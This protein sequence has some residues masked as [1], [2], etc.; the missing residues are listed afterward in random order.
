M[1]LSISDELQ[2]FCRE[3]RQHISPY[4]LNHLPK[5]VEFVQRRSKLRMQ[6][7]KVI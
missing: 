7:L 6:D 5:T 3:L 4:T 1:N 2:L